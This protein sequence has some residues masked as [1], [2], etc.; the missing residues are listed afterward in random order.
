MSSAPYAAVDADFARESKDGS[1]SPLRVIR[2]MATNAQIHGA[3]VMAEI[4]NETCASAN[5]ESFKRS[6]V[7]GALKDLLFALHARPRPGHTLMDLEEAIAAANRVL[8]EQ[9]PGGAA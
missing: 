1:V 5:R 2:E 9:A 4:L 8:D 7:K 3:P 6:Q